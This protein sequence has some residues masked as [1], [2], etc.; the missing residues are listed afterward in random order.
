[1]NSSLIER[2]EEDEFTDGSSK[3]VQISEIKVF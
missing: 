2:E 1:M 3:E